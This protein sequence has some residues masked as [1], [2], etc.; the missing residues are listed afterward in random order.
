MTE[1]FRSFIS[2]MGIAVFIYIVVGIVGF[3]GYA[4][5]PLRKKYPRYAGIIEACRGAGPDLKKLCDAAGLILFGKTPPSVLD[6]IILLIRRWSS[7][8]CALLTI[9]FLASSYGCGSEQLK[10]VSETCPALDRSMAHVQLAL[11]LAKTACSVAGDEKCNEIVN[12][13]DEIADGIEEGREKA[14]KVWPQL[15]LVRNFVK[16]EKLDAAIT[17]GDALLNCK[18]AVK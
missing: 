1:F 3:V 17:L 11:S 2:Q 6:G 4:A 5:V 9:A 10:Q 8:A 15:V 14:C 7:A 16:D 18:E 13:A 12:R